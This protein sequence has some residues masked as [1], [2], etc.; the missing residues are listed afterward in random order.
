MQHKKNLSTIKFRDERV[1]V[2]K[3]E[4]LSGAEDHFISTY[5]VKLRH[6][7]YHIVTDKLVRGFLTV[8]H[9]VDVDLVNGQIHIGSRKRHFKMPIGSGCPQ[10]DDLHIIRGFVGPIIVVPCIGCCR[11]FRK[12]QRNVMIGISD[13]C[14]RFLFTAAFH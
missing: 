7:S 1:P 8:N 6:I 13:F 3:K 10:T 11:T 5:V 2:F 12:D 4:R 14:C 9:V